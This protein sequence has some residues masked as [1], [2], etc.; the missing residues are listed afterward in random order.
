MIIGTG[1]LAK[2]FEAYKASK[3][4]YIF[5]SG[6]SNSK[7]TNPK[8]FK[9]E[10]DLLKSTIDDNPNVKLIYFSTVSINDASVNSSA[11]VQHKIKLEKLIKAKAAQY[12]IFRVS[13]VVGAKGNPNT[14]MNFLVTAVKE[15]KPITIWSKAERNII[16]VDDV[17]FIVKG[18]LSKN[19]TNTTIN[20]AVKESML[21][22][23]ILKQIEEFLQKKAQV[24][25]KEMGSALDIDTNEIVEY[26]ILIEQ[27]FG[28]KER[29]IQALLNKYY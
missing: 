18:V 16:D 29:Y 24:S 6:V 20:I 26:L 4:I 21:V 9:R 7:E 14:I 17:L 2:K 10:S 22:S 15:Q 5:A 12:I 28:A 8:A 27:K 1:L 23:G 3:D 19:I 25:F 11:Y 13:N